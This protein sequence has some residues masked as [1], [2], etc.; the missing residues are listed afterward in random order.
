MERKTNRKFL[1]I[2][3]I[4]SVLVLMLLL[5]GCRTRLTNNDEVISVAAEEDMFKQA[6]YEMR[7]DELGLGK[8]PKPFFNGFGS[9]P[10]EENFAEGSDDMQALEEYEPPDENENVIEV[11]DTAPKK[12][13]RGTS[14]KSKDGSGES[15]SEKENYEPAPQLIT[16]TL[17]P[18]G[19]ECE[20]ETIEVEI[21]EPYGKHEEL[22]VATREGYKFTGW[23]RTYDGKVVNIDADYTVDVTKPHTLRATWGQEV[24][25]VTFDLNG[26]GAKVV[27]GETTMSIQK[28]GNYGKPPEV[29][30]RGYLPEGWYTEAGDGK[31]TK[32][33]AGDKFTVNKD[34]TLYAHWKNDPEGYWRKKLESTTAGLDKT[35]RIVCSVETDDENLWALIEECG[36]RA[37]E[38]DE[39][40]QFVVAFAD[41]MS[42]AET[43]AER[44]PGK[45][46]VVVSKEPAAADDG[47]SLYSRLLLLNAL[48]NNGYEEAISGS[49][50]DL[51]VTDEDDTLIKVIDKTVKET[52]A[53]DQGGNAA[54]DAPEAGAGSG[55]GQAVEG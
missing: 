20:K 10:E 12:K 30:R 41:D 49:K 28:G 24:F 13:A 3:C 34:Q 32:I 19:G 4:A 37:P 17:D 15:E 35:S 48:N 16:V 43:I 26:D 6:E 1:R 33:E 52:P 54:P 11:D 14:R 31:G 38:G 47:R 46:V 50:E 23:T 55:T 39:E 29:D 36:G 18:N 7:R 8:A 9:A 42:Q 40:D 53:P 22:P 27:S 51:K 44:H 2:L 45:K 5:C 25:K 21:G